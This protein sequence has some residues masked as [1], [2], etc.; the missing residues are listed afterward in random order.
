[1]SILITELNWTEYME[2][3]SHT[4]LTMLSSVSRSTNAYETS[5]RIWHRTVDA[6]AVVFTSRRRQKCSVS[7]EFTCVQHFFHATHRQT[8]RKETT[9]KS[10]YDELRWWRRLTI[11]LIAAV[12]CQT[13]VHGHRLR[14]PTMDT[15]NRTSSQQF[16][17]KFATSQYAR[18]Q[19][20]D[21]S[22][23]WDVANFCPLVLNLLYNKL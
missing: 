10:E 3:H 20:L 8:Q 9:L 11:L 2:K 18:A 1:M 6:V 16:Y 13:P 7:H 15:T 17:N 4:L 23:C 21:M 12:K 5:R 14:T 19:H 22:R